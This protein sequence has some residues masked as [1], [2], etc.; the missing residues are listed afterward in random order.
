MRGNHSEV[1]CVWH[2]VVGDVVKLSLGDKVPADCVIIESQNLNVDERYTGVK[3][4]RATDS[5]SSIAVGKSLSQD[6]FLYADSFVASGYCTALVACVG[7]HSTRPESYR[8][9]TDL[10]KTELGVKL[11]NLTKTFTYLGLVFA[12]V[13]LT[14]AIA[15]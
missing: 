4:Q 2:L 1:K 8:P 14:S 10:T 12:L 9:S 5:G 7:L 15:I 11:G 3:Q 6:P 13:I